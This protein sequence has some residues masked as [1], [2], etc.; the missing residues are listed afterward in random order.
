MK[1]FRLLFQ[2]RN[3]IFY[4]IL[5]IAFLL[6]FSAIYYSLYIQKNFYQFSVDDTEPDPFGI[7]LNPQLEL[8][9]NNSSL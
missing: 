8:G 1:V 6:C 5:L 2:F 4:A 3:V 7:Y 9:A